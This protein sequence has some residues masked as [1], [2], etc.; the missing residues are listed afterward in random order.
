MKKSK[1]RQ[2]KILAKACRRQISSEDAFFMRKRRSPKA[3]VQVDVAHRVW[4]ALNASAAL[5]NLIP[6]AARTFFNRIGPKRRFRNV[7]SHALFG[8]N[9]TC[10]PKISLPS[11]HENA[12]FTRSIAGC[13][14]FFTL[15]QSFD[16]PPRAD[17][18]RNSCGRA[19]GGQP[20]SAP[21]YQRDPLPKNA[22]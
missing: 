21:R 9:Q 14:R 2:D 6:I 12:S 10:A 15:T 16:R 17:R 3:S 1:Y 4:T 20:E 8:A 5:K 18:M 19:G 11:D 7:C 22:S 13:L